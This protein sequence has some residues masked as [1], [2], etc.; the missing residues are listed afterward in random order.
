MQNKTLRQAAS[1]FTA[2][3]F[4]VFEKLIGNKYRD[5]QKKLK[6]K[7]DTKSNKKQTIPIVP[8]SEN[9]Q[10]TKVHSKSCILKKDSI[11]SIE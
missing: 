10:N 3:V 7:V 5:Y 9:T 4:R 8:V 2:H 11:K 6:Q 1:I